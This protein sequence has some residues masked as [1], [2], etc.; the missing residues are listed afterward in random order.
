MTSNPAATRARL[1]FR[2]GLFG[3][4]LLFLVVPGRPGSLVDGLPFDRMPEFLL[5]MGAV[6][7]AYLVPWRPLS[8]RR[9]WPVCVGDDL[10]PMHR[11][12][13]RRHEVRQ[14]C[15]RHGFGHLRRQ[16]V[17]THLQGLTLAEARPK[18]FRGF[19]TSR[20]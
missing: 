15:G 3:M 11:Q 8:R 1:W 19:S 6:G 14:C 17:A 10:Q 18:L 12:I 4:M 20:H 7:I 2:H 5:L 16:F 13:R 9:Q